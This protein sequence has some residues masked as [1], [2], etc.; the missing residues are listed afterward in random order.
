MC[1]LKQPLKL[2]IIAALDEE[3]IRI[4]AFG[5]RYGTHVDTLLDE[6]AGERLSRLLTTTVLVG[7]KGQVDGSWTV[8]KLT[9]LARIEIGA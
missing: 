2:V 5:K 6:P 7:I 3:A 8:A 4:L 1:C 9:E